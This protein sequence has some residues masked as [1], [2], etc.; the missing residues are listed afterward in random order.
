LG[1]RYAKTAVIWLVPA[2]LLLPLYLVLL[3]IAVVGAEGAPLQL[4]EGIKGKVNAALG[5][6]MVLAGLGLGGVTIALAEDAESYV[7]GGFGAVVA[8]G[9]GIVLVQTAIAKLRAS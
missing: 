4:V 6:L 1:W 9:L 5:P 2:L 3:V 7:F 8:V